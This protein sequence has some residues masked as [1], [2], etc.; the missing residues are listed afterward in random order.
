MGD[1]THARR[2]TRE[3]TRHQAEQQRYHPAQRIQAVQ[4]KNSREVDLTCTTGQT[5]MTA[6][7]FTTG[8][9]L[10]VGTYLVAWWCIYR[11]RCDDG[12]PFYCVIIQ[13]ILFDRFIIVWGEVGIRMEAAAKQ[14]R[15]SPPIVCGG[16]MS[17]RM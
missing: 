15:E 7:R 16:V 5:A 9:P 6:R 3:T 17:F 14:G 8:S 12:Q 4:G 13:K 2:A 11:T 1:E 10:I